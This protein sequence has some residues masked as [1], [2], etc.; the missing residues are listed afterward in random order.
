MRNHSNKRL[1]LDKFEKKVGKFLKEN[2]DEDHEEKRNEP[3]IKPKT[4]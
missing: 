2:E 3:S 1:L 4:N